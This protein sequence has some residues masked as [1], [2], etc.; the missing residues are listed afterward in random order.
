MTTEELCRKID[1]NGIEYV[2][3]RYKSE[4]TDDPQLAAFFDT[5]C[6]LRRMFDDAAAQFEKLIG[7][8]L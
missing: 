2:C 8:N 6:G 1:A 5:I 4:P 3:D 7:A